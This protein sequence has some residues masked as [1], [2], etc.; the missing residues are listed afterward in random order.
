MKISENVI[1]FKVFFLE[2]TN[3]RDKLKSSS[4]TENWGRDGDFIMMKKQFLMIP[5]TVLLTAGLCFGNAAS[6]LGAEPDAG[7]SISE[8]ASE[9]EEE[10]VQTP[11]EEETVGAAASVDMYR[12]YNPNSGEHFYTANAKE[13]DHLEKVGWNFEGVGWKAPKTSSTPVYR[14][15]NPNAGDHHYTINRKERDHLIS[16]GWKDEK[17]GWYSAKSATGVPVYRQ[18]NPNAKAGAHNFTTNKGE[19]NALVRVGWREEGIGWYAADVGKSLEE[20]AGVINIRELKLGTHHIDVDLDGKR[21]TLKL[22]MKRDGNNMGES[23]TVNYNG[24]T[25][26]IE[27]WEIYQTKFFLVNMYDREFLYMMCLAG[28]DDPFHTTWSLYNGKPELLEFDLE[29]NWDENFEDVFNITMY[30]RIDMI[31]TQDAE[32]SYHI[33]I[34]GRLVPNTKWY[35]LEKDDKEYD[36]TVKTKRKIRAEIVSDSA[37]SAV[38]TSGRPVTVPEGKRLTFYRTDAE[39][40]VDMKANDGTIYRFKMDGAYSEAENSDNSYLANTSI[41]G[42]FSEKL[43]EGAYHAG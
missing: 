17:I 34:T 12:L 10:E 7:I 35:S 2:I 11:T 4:Q 26:T 31:R 29:S 16:V 1:I 27:A 15:Y 19:N 22:S 30:N 28:S 14:L 3:Y 32:R 40:L 6:A 39:Q 23:V 13:R 37:L 38:P 43:F 8:N 41:D 9:A 24:N 33:G 21:D 20:C 18:Y 36:N 42:V 25:N 5:T